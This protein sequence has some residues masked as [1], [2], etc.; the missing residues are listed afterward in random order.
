MSIITRHAHANTIPTWLN[1]TNTNTNTNTN[2]PVIKIGA[3]TIWTT[4]LVDNHGNEG[5]NNKLKKKKKK[6]F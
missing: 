5:N 6:A 2:I 1:N 3:N 4:I